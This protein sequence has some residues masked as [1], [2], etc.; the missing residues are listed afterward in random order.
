MTDH[1]AF[2]RAMLDRPNDWAVQL[3]YADWL[4]EHGRDGR[5]L[6][7]PG[8]LM[9]DGGQLCWRVSPDFW[10]A[11]GADEMEI[12][13]DLRVPRCPV[14]GCDGFVMFAVGNRWFCPSHG[15]RLE[16]RNRRRPIPRAER[17]RRAALAA[18]NPEIPF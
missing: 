14:G 10:P 11:A 5:L 9:L 18:S 2:V 3:A 7:L 15:L 8:Y 1:D 16:L 13:G 6:R 4:D 12:A 17:R